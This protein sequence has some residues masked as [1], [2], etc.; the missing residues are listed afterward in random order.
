MTHPDAHA[1]TSAPRASEFAFASTAP[2]AIS[3]ALCLTLLSACANRVSDQV[4]TPPPNVCGDGSHISSLLT[5]P[6]G[7]H[8]FFGPAPWYQPANVNSL[9]C[10]YPFPVV[11]APGQPPPGQP[12]YAT[13]LTVTAVDT[14]DE[15]N[16][17]AIGSVYVQDTV[18]PTPIYGATS[19]FDPTYSPPGLRPQPGD[20]LD[21]NGT[22]EEYDGPT[23][24]MV[25]S[26]CETLPQ[27]TGAASFRYN[28]VVPAPVVIQPVDLSTYEGA[29]QYL[30]MLVTVENVV[31]AAAGKESSGRYNAS[32]AV[33]SG[34][35][36]T[37][38]DELFDLP[39]EYPLSQGE[40]FTS[41]TGIVTYFY[42]VQLAPRGV[43][44]FQGGPPPP[45]DAG[46]PP[47]DAGA[48]GG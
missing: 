32:V 21:V 36:W 26:Q 6:D 2:C 22:Y 7:S 15:T 20:V 24:S 48:D 46:T 39:D 33:P 47:A 5:N 23:S 31:I 10:D 12:V 27:I 37:I 40:S 16:D 3:L 17:G 13:C 41:V 35:T 9:N 43:Y 34:S 45:A 11:S 8:G 38:A 1:P 18:S 29:R 44:D 42:S 30:N 14:W 4:I 25:F 28:G 19:I